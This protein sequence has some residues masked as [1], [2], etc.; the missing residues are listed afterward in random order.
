MIQAGQE[1]RP[2]FSKKQQKTLVLLS[3]SFLQHAPWETKVF[4]F[5]FSKK[6]RLP[7]PADGHLFQKTEPS[8]IN[9]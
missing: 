6:N 3:R 8:V 7:C 9:P 5:F 1:A 4:R 2:A